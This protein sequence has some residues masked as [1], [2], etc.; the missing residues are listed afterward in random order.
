M[1]TTAHDYSWVPRTKDLTKHV[2]IEAGL[3]EGELDRLVAG[4]AG[5]SAQEPTPSP[6]MRLTSA[7]LRDQVQLVPNGLMGQGADLAEDSLT[8][9]TPVSVDVQAIMSTFNSPGPFPAS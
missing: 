7:E 3:N 8:S 6:I 1:R 2:P 9:M 4:T 5:S